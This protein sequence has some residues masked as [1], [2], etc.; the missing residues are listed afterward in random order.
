MHDGLR[1]KALSQLPQ[2]F[3]KLAL[4][5]CAPDAPKLALGQFLKAAATA[6]A[7]EGR[8]CLAAFYVLLDP[9]KIPSPESLDSPEVD[10]IVRE[11]PVILLPLY[12]IEVPAELGSDLWCRV[13]AW[14]NFIHT[15]KEHLPGP[16]LPEATFWVD[17]LI[18]TANFHINDAP[19]PYLY[20][21][22]GFKSLMTATW[23]FVLD[24]EDPDTRDLGL[25]LIIGLLPGMNPVDDANLE[26][27]IDAAGGVDYLAL[28]IIK[29]MHEILARAETP[30]SHEDLYLIHAVLN[31]V[32]E[33]E[34][35]CIK[36]Q[37]M[38]EGTLGRLGTSLA[39][40]DFAQVL[41]AVAW[42][43]GENAGDTD[44]IKFNLDRCFLLLA[45]IFLLETGHHHLPSAIS[46]GLLCALICAGQFDGTIQNHFTLFFYGILPRALISYHAVAALNAAL[47]DAEECATSQVFRRSP[48]FGPWQRFCALTKK[49]L[50]VLKFCEEYI[51]DKTCDNM[52]CNLIESKT[53]FSRCSG[54][55]NV[56]YCSAECQKSDW[57][58][59]GHRNVCAEYGNLTL[60]A[61]NNPSVRE[62]DF[63]RAYLD[64]EY[65]DSKGSIYAQHTL[66]LQR[67]P[68]STLVTVFD[69][70]NG[71]V[72]ISVH[73]LESESARVQE[74]RAY[75]AEWEYSVARARRS[76]GRMVLHVVRTQ[77]GRAAP[78]YVLVPLRKTG[79]GVDT[80]LEEF[81]ASL[82]TPHNVP[83]VEELWLKLRPKA[84][85][86]DEE[87]TETH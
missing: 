27:I 16:P 3:R 48:G 4:A 81:A 11:M 60:S 6:S 13:W 17:F 45:R 80:L 46:Q 62:R 67:F 49:S 40:L 21:S 64:A 20:N 59:G 31:F 25:T 28:L 56:Y 34:H 39:A 55:L 47:P 15:Y 10:D 29:C 7:S 41:V 22:V 65:T 77:Q 52:E 50:H 86:A 66:C 84:E 51:P 2:A 76:G 9:A 12:S 8:A 26:E 73:P 69:Y 43:V 19:A 58:T 68:N 42:T 24:V 53:E 87:V 54:C 78:R 30:L 74:L 5:A 61:R 35:L 82:P 32:A 33:A 37:P 75:G 38:Y 23:G 83:L 1:L 79:S 57:R 14:A 36:G 72:D 70:T 63:L 18:Y 71:P 85:A 44:V